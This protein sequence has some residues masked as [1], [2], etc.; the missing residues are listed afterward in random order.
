MISFVWLVHVCQWTVHTLYIYA[1]H[2]N[3]SCQLISVEFHVFH[4]FDEA[5]FECVL[6][7]WNC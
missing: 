1:R 2:G 3:I 5:V 7:G 6:S 4:V